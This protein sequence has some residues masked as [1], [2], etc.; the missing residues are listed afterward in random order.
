[1]ILAV[2]AGNSRIK[3]GVHDGQ[4]WQ[5]RGWAV[6]TGALP[7]SHDWADISAPQT[8]VVSNV[9]GPVVRRRLEQALA[10]WPVAVRWIAALPEQCGVRN[11]YQAPGQLGSDRWAALIA[12]WRRQAQACVVVNAGT[13][14][15]VD[16]LD[17]HGNFLGGMIAPGLA[18]MLRSLA[19][20]T[21]Q[22]DVA[23][24]RYSAFPGNTADAL[25]SGALAAM[26]GVVGRVQMALAQGAISRPLCLISGGDA[27]ALCELLGVG[28]TVV[29]N[30]VLD[31]LIEIA[32]E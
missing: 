29:D 22:L 24:G 12:A 28:A 16:A 4:G 30:L 31:G 25:Y 26:A 6:T 5:R 7:L 17:D 18:T 20:D 19:A 2:D 10:K 3:W 27:P 21:A 14:L 32:Q 8:I 1:M 13:A 15:T 23:P 11:G 9:A